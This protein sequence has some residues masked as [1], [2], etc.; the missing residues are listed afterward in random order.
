MYLFKS[1]ILLDQM[2]HCTDMSFL[3]KYDKLIV[4]LG[5]GDGKLL[6]Q[7]STKDEDA[8][9]FYLGIEIDGSQYRK[10][11]SSLSNRTHNLLFV[12]SP[13]EEIIAN[14]PDYSAD[15]ILSILPHP[16]YIDRKNER[17]W[18]PIYKTIFSKI[19]KN[20]HLLLITEF[21]DE[22]FSPVRYNDYVYWKEWIIETFTDLGFY[23]GNIIEEVPHNYTSKFIDLF[24][25]DQ[26]R[27]KILTLYLMKNGN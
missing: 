11:N 24:S 18:R 10:N 7:L 2:D 14:L 6:Y 16:K 13:F 15:E 20:G 17:F 1:N 27:I 19:K 25:N 9:T 4:E 12:N 22:L 23:V 5:C 3:N 26:E 8:N 21:T